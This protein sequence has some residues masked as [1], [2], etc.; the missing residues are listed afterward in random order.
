VKDHDRLPLMCQTVTRFA[1][2]ERWSWWLFGLAHCA[3]MKAGL[4]YYD[5]NDHLRLG[6][7]LAIPDHVEVGDERRA[8]FRRHCR[9]M[10]V[11]ARLHLSLA[12]R[13]Q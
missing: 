4:I 6:L 10:V 3:M 5:Q 7:E 12:A 13:Q 8:A 1:D 9:P 11:F 2:A